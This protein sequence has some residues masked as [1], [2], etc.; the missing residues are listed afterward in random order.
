MA[1]QGRNQFAY[2]KED[3]RG[4]SRAVAAR[5]QPA[6]RAFYF[7]P[8]ATGRLDCEAQLDAMWAG[9]EVGIPTLNGYSSNFPKGW[10]LLESA[11][12]SQKDEDRLRDAL[13]AWCEQHHLDPASICWVRPGHEPLS[14]MASAP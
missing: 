6:C 12:G 14:W 8:P 2:G 3:A 9:L 10:G 5:L 7:S 11:I 1:E 13:S 4:W